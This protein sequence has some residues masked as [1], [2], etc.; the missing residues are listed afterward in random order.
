MNRITSLVHQHL[1]FVHAFAA[2]FRHHHGG[3]G[4]PLNL[5][6]DFTHL[7]SRIPGSGRPGYAL[8]APRP[9]KPLPSSPARAASTDAF[10]ASIFDWS[11]RLLTVAI[12]SPICCVCSES[13]RMLSAISLHAA[14]NDLHASDGLRNRIR[15]DFGNI[16][17]D[18]RRPRPR[19]GHVLPF[20]SRWR[21]PR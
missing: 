21:A 7:H 11:A 14:A 13:T 9:R 19:S 8:P 10:N 1:A 18:L 15:A 20:R 3:V 5:A 16:N 12:I 17:R 2:L 4:R 6:Q